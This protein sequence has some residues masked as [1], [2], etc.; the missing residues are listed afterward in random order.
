MKL[1]MRVFPESDNAL[2]S[3]TLG[4]NVIYIAQGNVYIIGF[5]FWGGFKGFFLY[6]SEY[7]YCQY[8][9]DKHI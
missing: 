8:L 2:K 3:I 7:K 4:D 9:C 5:L 1:F 6:F